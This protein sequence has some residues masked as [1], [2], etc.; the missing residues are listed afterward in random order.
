MPRSCLTILILW[1]LIMT[2]CN[3]SEP[4]APRLVYPTAQNGTVVDDY[5]G[6]KVPD[7]YRWMEALDSKEVADWVAASNAVT[8]PYLARLPLRAHFN[9]RLTELWNYPRVGM[10][11][12]E[13]GKLFYTKN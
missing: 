1:A 12:S 3:R 4:G 11:V 9:S 13:G 8:D 6:T 5:A 7:P 10:P 2:A